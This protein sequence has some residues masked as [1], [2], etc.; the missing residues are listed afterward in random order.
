ML[1]AVAVTSQAGGQ[2]AAPT[3]SVSLLDATTTVA[4][5]LLTGGAASFALGMLSAGSHTLTCA[6][7]GDTNY[8]PSVSAPLIVTIAAAGSGDFT[9]AVSGAAGMTVPAGGAATYSF[10]VTP[11]GAALNSPINLAVSGLP[12][13]ASGTFNP[14]Y[15]PPPGGPA[16]FSLTVTSANTAAL[17]PALPLWPRMT[18]A[19][20]LL[21]MG[22]AWRRRKG[23]LLA[24]AVL[25]AGC[26]SRVNTANATGPA[27]AIYNLTVT[28]TATS[29]KGVALVHT[30]QLTLTVQS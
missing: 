6:Y 12:V 18:L 20:A 19:A 22:L 28:A 15:V 21:G 11:A 27:A 16:A 17:R 30:A 5:A 9:L 2:A 4:S 24:G 1:L 7:S 23:L 8:L 26:G 10:T 29:A 3:G 25:L 14:A 13:G